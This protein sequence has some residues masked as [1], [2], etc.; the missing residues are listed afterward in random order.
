M[1]HHI[2]DKGQFQSDKHPDLAPGKIILSFKDPA[3]RVALSAF[4]LITDD[5]ELAEDIDKCLQDV[6]EEGDAR[7]LTKLVVSI[8]PSAAELL[9]IYSQACFQAEDDMNDKL[10]KP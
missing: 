9:S 7:Y 5:E 3:A 10:S 1:G 4:A 6:A 2:N 8:M